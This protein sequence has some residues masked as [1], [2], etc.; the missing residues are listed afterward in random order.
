MHHYDVAG[1][2]FR[3]PDSHPTLVTITIDPA[4]WYD[5]QRLDADNPDT[6]I[7]GHQDAANAEMIVWV[8]CISGEVAD[9]LEDGWA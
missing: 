2:R 3:L 1:R 5:L 9:R 8:A 4:H 6:I 7:I